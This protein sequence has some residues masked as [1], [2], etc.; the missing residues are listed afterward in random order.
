M[1]RLLFIFLLVAGLGAGHADA[2]APT[3]AA[4]QTTAAAPYRLNIQD[5][6]LYSVREDPIRSADPD[7]V[8]VNAQGKAHFRVSAGFDDIVT[9]DAVG[10]TLTQLRDELHRRLL[11]KYYEQ[12]TIELK[13][14]Q[15]TERAGKVLLYGA[16][17][18]N[19]LQLLPGE[20]K[21]IFEAVYQAGVTEYAN[22][23]KVK[24]SRLNSH[25]G[26]TDSWIINLEVIK[27][28]DR[29]M[30]VQLLDGDRIE[31]PEKGLVF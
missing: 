20:T 31:V 2:Q 21:T 3:N 6:L 10:K 11:E 13:L 26:Q 17:R 9:L 14:K 29:T 25:T 15:S 5:K 1:K 30:D 8:F 16:V 19:F 28:G 23:K 4:P 12:A 22:L 18:S 24:L 27:K 7:E